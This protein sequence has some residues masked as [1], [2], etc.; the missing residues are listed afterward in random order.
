MIINEGNY[1]EKLYKVTLG[2]GLIWTKEFKVYA[3]NETEAIDLV[4]DYIEEKELGSLY[5][6]WY[7]L[8]DLCEGNETVDEYAEA[9][10]LTCCGNHGI[11]VQIV[12][13][14]ELGNG[15]C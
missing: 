2:T 11:Y 7:G 10:G 6:D 4:A 3:Y 15:N 9:N 5:T 8:F 14:E 13:M 1:G 12:G